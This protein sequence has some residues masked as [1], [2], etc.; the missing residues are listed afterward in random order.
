MVKLSAIKSDPELEREGV[1]QDY[2]LG[3][4]VKV[5]RMGNQAF[6]ECVR[7]LS[8]P[9]LSGFRRNKLPSEV[10]ERITKQA[11]ARHILLGWEGI[12]GEDGKPLPYSEETAL[13]ILN[14]PALADFYKFVLL[15]ANEAELFRRK[16]MEEA[17]GN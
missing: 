10:L 9:H 5:A 3:I 14:D 13:E 17:A 8:E 12:D 1:W 15:A 4:R 11:V 7:K 16:D 6:D 2:E